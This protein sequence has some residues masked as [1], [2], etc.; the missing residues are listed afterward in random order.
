MNNDI[1]GI[2]DVTE[3]D[4]KLALAKYFQYVADTLN[5]QA[6]NVLMK[7]KK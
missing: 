5:M 7:S 6:D 1:F 3:T 4:K 2:E